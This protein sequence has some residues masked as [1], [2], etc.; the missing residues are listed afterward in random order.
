MGTVQELGKEIT[1]NLHGQTYTGT[2]IYDGTKT[3]SSMSLASATARN[4][5]SAASVLGSGFSTT[6]I[7]G[8]GD[9]KA[10]VICGNNTLRCDFNAV[11]G[12]GIGYCQDNAGKEYDLL[13][14]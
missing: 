1:I 8:S 10:L 4:G 6:H 9:G 11:N 7:P 3:I 14:R 2:Y 5:S 13:I 12:K